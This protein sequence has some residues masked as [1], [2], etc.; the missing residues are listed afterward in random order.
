MGRKFKYMREDFGELKIKQ[1]HLTL[2][3]NFIDDRVEVTNIL[4][5]TANEDLESIKLNADELTALS[6]FAEKQ[7]ECEILA[8]AQTLKERNAD[9][10]GKHF[11]AG[12]K[13][14]HSTCLCNSN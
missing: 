8:S 14:C 3:L 10:A 9:F 7:K 6:R 12:K 4:D 13:S 2:S 1:N 11:K 5:L